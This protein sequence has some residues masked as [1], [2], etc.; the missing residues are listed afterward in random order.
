MSSTNISET[1]SEPRDLAFHDAI[2]QLVECAQTTVGARPY[3]RESLSTI[4][5]A[6]GA[7][8]GLLEVNLMSQVV[9]ESWVASLE[10]GAFWD[11]TLQS[12]LIDALSERGARA[13]L[14]KSRSTGGSSVAILSA[15]VSTASGRLNGSIVVVTSCHGREL[16]QELLM[17]LTALVSLTAR[18]LDSLGSE[19]KQRG[20]SAGA[21][22]LS[23][24]KRASNYADPTELSFAI[25]N[26]LRSR[27]DF[28][29]VAFGRVRGTGI[30]LLSISG[31]DEVSRKSPGARRIHTAMEEC[32]DLGMPVV[33]QTDGRLQEGDVAQSGR[34]HAAWHA[35][36]AGAAVASIPL[37]AE[38]KVVAVLACRRRPN[39]SYKQGDLEE[40]RELVEPYVGALEVVERASRSLCSHLSG[41]LRDGLRR[42][43][44][45]GHLGTKL[46]VLTPLALVV[47][48]AFGQ[49]AYEITVPCTLEVTNARHVGTPGDGVLADVRVRPGDRVSTGDLLCAFDVAGSELE[50]EQLRAELAIL[51]IQRHRA[52]AEDNP[53][54]VELARANHAQVAANLRLV[55][56]RIERSKVRAAID[57]IVVSGDLHDRLGDVFSKGEPLFEVA[58]SDRWG[59]DLEI[60]ERDIAEIGLGARGEF[61]SLA[62][63]GDMH[64]FRVEH[65]DHD[66]EERDG[67]NIYL[68]EA[69][70]DANRDWLRPG[71]EGLA[72]VR[73]GERAAWWVLFHR[74]GD[75]IRVHLWL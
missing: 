11:K 39:T 19:S 48:L 23:N 6:L 58:S 33:H 71:M 30:Q 70:T 4:A 56:H 63:P 49:L 52:M 64:R 36:A 50:L 25:T 73:L 31:L 54:E 75:W 5:K 47:W 7:P 40:L 59:L 67:S 43:L 53:A 55:E 8:A 41:S 9:T 72:K 20:S 44:Q 38:G 27:E 15:P 32:L 65:V 68:A 16:A 14:Y 21:S 35:E 10:Q 26:K 17:T 37:K 62:R 22:A 13:R 66:A 57:G 3:L 69:R 24:L 18:L 74:A 42:L 12:V 45:W 2:E 61:F 29:L 28:D 60:H 46:A 1:A 34:V 51:E